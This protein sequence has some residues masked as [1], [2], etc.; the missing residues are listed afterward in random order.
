MPIP[1]IRAALLEDAAA[2]SK[3]LPDLGYT[4]TAAECRAR[5]QRLS[6]WP[7]N[8]VFVA[9]AEAGGAVMALCHLQG[10]PL[11]ASAGYVEVQALVVAVSAQRTG[12]G[13][14][15]LQHAVLWAQSQGYPRVRLRSGLHRDEAHRFYE[16]QG[17]LKSKAS[18]AFE[19]LNPN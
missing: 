10:V 3:L 19:K 14:A 7:Q 1:H 9:E 17:F 18:Y 12:V 4:A 8:E 2:I 15:L 16:A 6:Q 13:R 11:L 5:L